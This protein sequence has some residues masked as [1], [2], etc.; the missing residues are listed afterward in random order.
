MNTS[1]GQI[2]MKQC[3]K[4][5]NCL[6]VEGG[7]LPA[8]RE[9]FWGNRSKPDG[10]QY[11]CKTCHNAASS[12]KIPTD[13]TINLPKSSGKYDIGGEPFWT[14]T[15]VSEFTG[16]PRST[17][18]DIVSRKEV[19]ARR[20]DRTWLVDERGFTQLIARYKRDKRVPKQEAL[21][22]PPRVQIVMDESSI[23]QL[24]VLYAQIR[25]YL[26]NIGRLPPDDP[27]VNHEVRS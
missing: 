16:V 2:R 12:K 7:W 8:T 14:L 19:T 21:P 20:L 17:L 11:Y 9:Y 26:G 27:Q 13:I 1:N 3:G 4:R 15:E 22:E 25:A 24:Q 10:L 6:T 23:E 18:H 5:E